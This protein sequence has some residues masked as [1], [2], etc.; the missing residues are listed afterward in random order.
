[1]KET[2][3]LF[4]VPVQNTPNALGQLT[5]VLAKHKINLT[6]IIS[7]AGE[8][9]T[10]NISFTTDADTTKVLSVLRNAEFDVLT[11]PAFIVDLEN[12]PGE[13][14]AL[15]SKL[16]SQYVNIRTISGVVTPGNDRAQILIVVSDPV[17][18][19]EF[20]EEYSAELS[21]H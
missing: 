8:S 19:G 20:I 16:G 12:V 5:R 1:M 15:A 14:E 18:A 9:K 10:T 7:D 2:K 13:L 6:S 21:T 11:S 17:R 3:T 4:S